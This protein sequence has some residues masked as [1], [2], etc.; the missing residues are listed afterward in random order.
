MG[1]G[2]SKRTRVLLTR[3]TWLSPVKYCLG[4]TVRKDSQA[5]LASLIAL[6]ADSSGT[7]TSEFRLVLSHGHRRLVGVSVNC[8][9]KPRSLKNN[10]Q[11]K[12]KLKLKLK[13][14]K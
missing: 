1:S 8:H 5:R 4:R 10:L 9:A 12:L 14:K 11:P 6:H 7:A 2:A 3:E 13:L